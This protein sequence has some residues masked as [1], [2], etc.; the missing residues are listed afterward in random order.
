MSLQT[1]RRSSKHYDGA[2]N[3]TEPL[4]TLRWRSKLYDAAPNFMPTQ[5][6]P[7]QDP[8][9]P[10]PLLPT[11]SSPSPGEEGEQPAFPPAACLSFGPEAL[12]RLR[13]R[14]M[15]AVINMA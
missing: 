3:I 4:Q 5:R 15:I 6:S 14:R 2:R 12:T 9:H 13:D 10:D 1:L 7:A 8:H 11:P